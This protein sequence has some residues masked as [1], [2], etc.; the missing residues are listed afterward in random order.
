MRFA[1]AGRGQAV[2]RPGA[3]QSAAPR[4][5]P[6]KRGTLPDTKDRHPIF[7][8]QRIKEENPFS[9]FRVV[10]MGERGGG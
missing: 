7:P 1:P 8:N 2:A 3:A 9:C 5:K 4:R 6:A 10:A